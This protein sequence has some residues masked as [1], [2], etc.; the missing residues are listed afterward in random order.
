MCGW[1]CDVSIRAGWVNSV[2]V[3]GGIVY[4]PEVAVARRSGKCVSAG[5]S[6]VGVGEGPSG[7]TA[8]AVSV[9]DILKS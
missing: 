8:P 5:R 1:L 7:F 4:R 2:R 9:G 3:R 6:A